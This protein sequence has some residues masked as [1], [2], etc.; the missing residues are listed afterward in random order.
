MIRTPY[1]IR[2]E[3]TPGRPQKPVRDKNYLK[4]IRSLPSA[5]SGR[6][7]CEACH[8]GPHGT[9][10][11]SSDLSCI[12]L[13]RKEHREFDAAPR[14]YVEK[15]GLDISA[16]IVRLNAAYELQQAGKLKRGMQ[17]EALDAA[18]SQRRERVA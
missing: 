7:G 17:S 18:Q 1:G 11:K 3:F 10:Q 4:F 15:H 2:S 8:T 6:Y 16:L 9:G 13:T 5:V 12:P 14:L